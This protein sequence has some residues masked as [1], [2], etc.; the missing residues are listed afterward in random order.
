MICYDL[1]GIGNM[2]WSQSFEDSGLGCYATL[3]GP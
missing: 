3:T 1:Y 2:L